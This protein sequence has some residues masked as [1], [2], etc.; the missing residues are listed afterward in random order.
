M[1]KVVNSDEE[2]TFTKPVS[3]ICRDFIRCC[4]KR[5]AEERLNVY[6]LIRHPFLNAQKDSLRKFKTDRDPLDLFFED[7]TPT[8]NSE[9]LSFNQDQDGSL[10]RAVTEAS[11]IKD[12]KQIAS[13]YRQPHLRLP[14]KKQEETSKVFTFET[15]LII[16]SQGRERMFTM[17]AESLSKK[18]SEQ[19]NLHKTPKTLGTDKLTSSKSERSDPSMMK[20]SYELKGHEHKTLRIPIVRQ[21]NTSMESN[22]P[23]SS[24]NLAIN[25]K[26]KGLTLKFKA[27]TTVGSKK[28]ILNLKTKHDDR[29]KDEYSDFDFDE[30]NEPEEVIH[31]FKITIKEKRKLVRPIARKPLKSQRQSNNDK[32]AYSIYEAKEVDLLDN[33]PT[34]EFIEVPNLVLGPV[35]S[36]ANK[37]LRSPFAVPRSPL[38]KTAKPYTSPEDF[39][40]LDIN[41]SH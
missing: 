28:P 21:G 10:K 27:D 22:N 29:S 37:D 3:D 18:F 19:V 25:Y 39:L 35:E 12:F 9:E 26:N 31:E 15:P 13:K 20:Q 41:P 14:S 38:T 40:S 23:E 32:T 5:K 8:K 11:K 36:G 6:K 24:R 1:S 16:D 4:M 34:R 30:E 33:T 2:P 7:S 17:P